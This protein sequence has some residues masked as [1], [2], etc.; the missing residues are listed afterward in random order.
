MGSTQSLFTN[1]DIMTT[2]SH[3]FPRINTDLIIENNKDRK[4]NN[5]PL[6]IK[7]KEKK[8]RKIRT[9]VSYSSLLY[10]HTY[11]NNPAIKTKRKVSIVI[12]SNLTMM[13]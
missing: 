6:E 11:I 8:I 5:T 10:W 3:C 13:L 2:V 7:K 1:A 9:S 12:F 4:H